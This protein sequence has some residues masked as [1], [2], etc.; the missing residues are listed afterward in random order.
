MR[1]RSR[2][3]TSFPGGRSEADGRRSVALV[4]EGLP[5]RPE[6]PAA[7]LAGAVLLVA[8]PLVVLLRLPGATALHSLWAEDGTLFLADAQHHSLGD[9]VV[10]GYGGYLHLPARLIAELATGVPIRWAPAVMSGLSAVVAG[11][12]AWWVFWTSRH[13]VRS[14]PVRVLLALVVLVLPT[15]GG[16]V[17]ANAANLHW[18]LLYGALWALLSPSRTTSDAVAGAV[19]VAAATT[20]DAL[21]LLLVPL[22][23]ARAVVW[24]GWCREHVVTLAFV[25][26]GALQALAVASIS[27]TPSTYPDDGAEV[28]RVLGARWVAAGTAGESTTYSLLDRFGWAVVAAT[29]V[30]VAVAVLLAARGRPRRT[31]ALAAALLGAGLV[32]AGAALLLR[33]DDSMVPGLGPPGILGFGGRY[34]VVPQLC[35]VAALLC[36]FEPPLPFRLPAVRVATGALAVVLAIS[37]ARDFRAP[38]DRADGVAWGRAIEEAR[39]GCGTAATVPVEISPEGWAVDVPCSLLVDGPGPAG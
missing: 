37:W 39:K 23:L 32:Y 29:A 30:L 1:A 38:N 2:E 14:V 22:A 20:A 4:L 17:L 34:F 21:T 6:S 15:A 19:V 11:L 18:F 3:A 33:W 26:G 31:R 35:L 10:R 12:V 13:H 36:L 7:R 9:S 28:L 24:R 27:G 8:S 5:D 25:A 16:E